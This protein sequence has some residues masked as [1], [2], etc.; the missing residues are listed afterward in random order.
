MA[1]QHSWRSNIHEQ[2]TTYTQHILANKHIL[3][4]VVVQGNKLHTVAERSKSRGSM[5]VKVIGGLRAVERARVSCDA[6]KAD[7][8]RAEKDLSA[9]LIQ[10]GHTG[11]VFKTVIF[12]RVDTVIW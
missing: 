5:L 7:L 9:L 6:A 8:S 2:N 11:T 3:A 12:D 1:A 10:V 4:L